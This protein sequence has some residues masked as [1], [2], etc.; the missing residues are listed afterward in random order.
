MSIR[1][2]PSLLMAATVAVVLASGAALLGYAN[3]VYTAVRA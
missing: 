1:R 2:L 3:V